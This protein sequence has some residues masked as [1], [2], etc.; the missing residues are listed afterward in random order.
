MTAIMKAPAGCASLSVNGAQFPVDNF[1]Y[2]EIPMDC[3]KHALSRGFTYDPSDY[4]PVEI[5]KVKEPELVEVV[6]K[7]EDK[8]SGHGIE[9]TEIINHDGTVEKIERKKKSKKDA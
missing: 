6:F 5:G 4:R 9:P 7:N 3:M 2:A 1:G 8:F